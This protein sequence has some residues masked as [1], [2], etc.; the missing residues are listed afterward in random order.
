MIEFVDKDFN[1]VIINIKYMIQIIKE[2][3]DLM[4]R[5]IKDIIK[6]LNGNLRNEK[7][8]RQDQWQ[9]MYFKRK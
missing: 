1:I 4:R 5:E 2:N 7:Y 9:M 3:M 8:V 6:D